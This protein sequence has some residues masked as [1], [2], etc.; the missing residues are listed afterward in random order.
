MS[1]KL[2]INQV[3]TSATHTLY[4]PGAVILLLVCVLFSADIRAE[5][6]Q[7]QF[8]QISGRGGIVDIANAGDGSGRLFLVEQLGR[9][10][11]HQDGA[12]LETPFLNIASIKVM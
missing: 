7:L 2:L 4:G 1:L 6:P 8:T 5:D 10:F 9:I 3:K 11:I 12:D